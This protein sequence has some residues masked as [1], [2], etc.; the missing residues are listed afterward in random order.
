MKI[1]KITPISLLLIF[2]HSMAQN[3]WK[4]KTKKSGEIILTDSKTNDKLANKGM[5]D[6]I[7]FPQPKETDI[8]VFI[9][10]NFKY[11]KLIGIGG[12]ITDASAETFAKLPKEQ[13]TEFLEAYLGTSG[14]GYNLV[15]TNKASCVF[16]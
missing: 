8:C 15:R 12:A 4:N 9:D 5:V 2:N 14:I 11:Q 1:Q 16:S 6:F 3:F 13:Q 10:P 7:D